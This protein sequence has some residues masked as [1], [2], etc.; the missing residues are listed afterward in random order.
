MKTQD[1]HRD[2]M[3]EMVRRLTIGTQQGVVEWKGNGSQSHDSFLAT[4]ADK[5]I[6]VKV[7]DQFGEVLVQVLGKD[8]KPIVG[9]DSTRIQT[10]PD[11]KLF[12]DLLQ[13]VRKK[14]GGLEKMLDEI[15]AQLPER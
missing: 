15:L 10:Q 13:V 5:T 1:M 14:E 9:I 2:K 8:G 3:L 11:R 4:V 6:H 7:E 12:T